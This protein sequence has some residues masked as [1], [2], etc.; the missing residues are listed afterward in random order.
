VL[1][2]HDAYSVDEFGMGDSMLADYDAIAVVSVED[3]AVV[4]HPRVV[5]VANGSDLHVEAYRPSTGLMLLFVGPF[6]YGPNR[7]GIAEFLRV[8]WPQIRAAVPA[9]TL[10]ILAGDEYPAHVAGHDAFA[11]P[12][13]VLCGH[14]DD[15]PA[16]LTQC[17]MT[18]NPLEG[19][20]GS[21]VKIAESL[22]AGRVCVSTLAGAR[23]YV[24]PTVAGLVTVATVESMVEPLLA[25][26]GDAATRHRLEASACANAGALGWSGSIRNLR[27]LHANL[28][29]AQER[30]PA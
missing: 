22:A 29:D 26:L 16:L 28:L 3:A 11:Q 5:L 6:R 23:G 7:E 10:L 27:A 4:T 25:L 12:G 14:R 15:V 19:I 1:D 9:A 20:R 8:A 21:A 18:I 2:L 24:K 13:V 30:T 17:A